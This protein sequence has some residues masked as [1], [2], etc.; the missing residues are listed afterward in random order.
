VLRP[1]FFSAACFGWF[2]DEKSRIAKADRLREHMSPTGIAGPD[3]RSCRSL[4]K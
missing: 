4:R 2:L 3:Q 1:A